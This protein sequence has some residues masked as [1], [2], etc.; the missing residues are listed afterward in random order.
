[1]SKCRTNL[2]SVILAE[3]N[4]DSKSE[5]REPSIASPLEICLSVVV[6]R[7]CW[8][9]LIISIARWRNRIAGPT[10]ENHSPRNKF[11][12]T[13]HNGEIGKKKQKSV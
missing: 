10:Q 12:L 3:M 7:V 8:I 1:M 6:R 2:R 4:S 9:S 13:R 5:R 11:T